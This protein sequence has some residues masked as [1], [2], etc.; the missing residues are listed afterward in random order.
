MKPGTDGMSPMFP[1]IIAAYFKTHE[2]LVSCLS[3][4]VSHSKQHTTYIII[5]RHQCNRPGFHSYKNNSLCYKEQSFRFLF[6]MIDYELCKR[7]TQSTSR[8]QRLTVSSFYTVHNLSYEIK[9][10]MIVLYSMKSY[11][12]EYEVL[13]YCIDDV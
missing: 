3:P 10:W 5:A 8:S 2:F 1:C 4:C 12:L 9:T 6:R 11:S 7:M 13:I